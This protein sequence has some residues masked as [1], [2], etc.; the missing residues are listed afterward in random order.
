MAN[1]NILS[2]NNLHL[3]LS[4]GSNW[5]W[6]DGSVFDYHRFVRGPDSNNPQCSALKGEKKK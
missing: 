3:T 2:L 6:T 1:F 4:Q 5:I